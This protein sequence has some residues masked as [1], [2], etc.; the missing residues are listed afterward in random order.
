MI[1]FPQFPYY[2]AKTY[3]DE[4]IILNLDPILIR[5][6]IDIYDSKGLTKTAIGDTVSFEEIISIRDNCIDD[7]ER[8]SIKIEKEPNLLITSTLD[9]V[10]AK[11]LFNNM[12]KYLTP[13]LASNN[14]MWAYLNLR[15][16]PDIVVYRWRKKKNDEYSINPERFFKI[17][18]N[19]CGTLWWRAYFFCDKSNEKDNWWL[20]KELSED[21]LVAITERTRLRGYP[22]LPIQLGKK[23]VEIN[24]LNVTNDFKETLFR[25]MMVIFLARISCINLHLLES[26][27]QSIQIIENA[28][29]AAYN[30][31]I[32]SYQP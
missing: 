10:F 25:K 32:D 16:F 17:T 26:S 21:N 31:L 8:Q 30:E 18:R 29:N 13:A 24:N 27:N 5:K 4:K 14:D 12:D 7:L 22:N 6:Q 2:L 28:Y 20:L 11:S 19:Y 3:Y 15:V 9:Y 1:E 23:K